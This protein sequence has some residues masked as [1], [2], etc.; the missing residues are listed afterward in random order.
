LKFVFI[1]Q[2]EGR[3]HLTQAIS[4]SQILRRQGHEVCHVLVGKTPGRVVPSYFVEKIGSDVTLFDSPALVL[5]GGNRK[6]LIGSTLRT[7]IYHYQKYIRSLKRIN[8]V[9]EKFKPDAIINF[10]ELMAG[11]YFWR[12]KPNVLHICVAHQYLI[13]HPVFQFPKGMKTDKFMLK[14]NNKMASLRADRILALSF[15]PEEDLPDK[16]MYIAPPLLR[17]EIFNLKPA[18]GDYI[19]GYMVYPGYAENVKEWHKRNSDINAVF[20][21]NRTDVPDNYAINDK[22]KFCRLNDEKF[23]AYMAGCKAYLTSAGFESV[24]EA[25]YLGKAI[26]VVPTEG[27]YEQHCNGEDAVRTGI[28]AR[29]FDYDLGA[30]MK[31][32]QTFQQKDN[33]FQQWVESAPSRFLE[34]IESLPLKNQ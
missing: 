7:N 10:Y 16:K 8:K 19:L 17:S 29:S 12:Y 34:L 30:L 6:I 13:H 26:M 25:A 21:W 27:H 5:D 3:G 11:L 32:T 4:M 14:L 15:Q 31:Y 28:A 33:S 22:L 23:L 2:G 1:V 9:V 20:F 24:C 18:Q